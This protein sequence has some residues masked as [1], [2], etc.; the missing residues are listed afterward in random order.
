MLNFGLLYDISNENGDKIEGYLKLI[1]D[2]KGDE[3]TINNLI[4]RESVLLYT[5]WL[6]GIVLYAGMDC[7]IFKN[8]RY[9]KGK[10]DK[11]EKVK[12][13]F[14]FMCLL[15]NFVMISV[16]DHFLFDFI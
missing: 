9:S 16:K 12:S 2:P 5:E 11:F 15:L 4:F 6:V 8:T 13:R 3:I 10:L 1:N 7:H 14:F